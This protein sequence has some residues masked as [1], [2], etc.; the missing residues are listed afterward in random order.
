MTRYEMTKYSKLRI[1]LYH[2]LER[3]VGLDRAKLFKESPTAIFKQLYTEDTKNFYD[4]LLTPSLAISKDEDYRKD[5]IAHFVCR[6]LYC[7]TDRNKD[8]FI[9][10]EKS[11]LELRLRNDTFLKN[12]RSMILL[13]GLLSHLLNE[14]VD[15]NI[16]NEE[17]MSLKPKII[18]GTAFM[19]T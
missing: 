1:Y 19:F 14:R 17:W 15:F 4:F 10:Y 2:E 18:K 11:I 3:F 9:T 12:D 16:P 6:M 7:R 8:D 5:N 13:K